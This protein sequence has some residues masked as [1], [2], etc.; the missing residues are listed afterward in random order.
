VAYK[1]EWT[2][3]SRNDYAG[4]DGS[5]LV[6]VDKALVRIAADGMNAG[7]P[8]HGELIGCNKLK[9]KKMGLRIVFR[10]SESGVEIVQIV[11][12]GARKNSYV[13]KL[14]TERIKK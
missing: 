14:A 2:E 9:N 6:F 8:L 12:I 3:Y 5:R 11:A 13:Y 7:Q 1:I 4:L 10:Q